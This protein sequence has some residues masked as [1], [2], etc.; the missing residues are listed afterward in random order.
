MR[1]LRPGTL[2]RHYKNQ[3]YYVLSSGIHSET[4][5]AFAVYFP[6]YGERVQLFVRPLTMFLERLSKDLSGLQ[7]ER[8]LEIQKID[9]PE[10]QKEALLAQAKTRLQALLGQQ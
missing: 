3:W 8:F 10:E 4:E 5:E 1:T 7:D 2:Y 9:L 6:L